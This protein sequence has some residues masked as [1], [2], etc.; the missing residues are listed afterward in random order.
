MNLWHGSRL[1][2]M[3]MSLDD[4]FKYLIHTLSVSTLN[5]LEQKLS[6]LLDEIPSLETIVDTLLNDLDTYKEKKFI[7]YLIIFKSSSILKFIRSS[8]D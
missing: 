7:L 5:D 6:N 8:S 3:I 4:F 1:I 2:E